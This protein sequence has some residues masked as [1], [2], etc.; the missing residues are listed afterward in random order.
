MESNEKLI[1]MHP[2][3]VSVSSEKVAQKLAKKNISPSLITGLNKCAASWLADTFVIRDLIEEEPDN[4]ARRGTLFHKVMED[5]FALPKEER[6]HETLKETYTAVLASDEFK[7]MAEMREAVVWLRR[8]INNYLNMGAQP[9]R[10]NVAT[11]TDAKGRVHPGLEVFVKGQI[12]NARRPTLGFIDRLVAV[13]PDSSTVLIEDWKTGGTAKRWNPATKSDDG[14][15]EARQQV[16]YSMLLEQEYGKKVAGARLIFPMALDP[17]WKASKEKDESKP[18]Y[19]PTLVEVD[20]KDEAFRARVVR[21]V[22]EADKKL[23]MMIE[24]NEFPYTPNFLCA[25]CPLARIC[26]A[27]SIKPYKKMQD[28]Y[29][30]QP[31]PELLLQTIEVR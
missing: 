22:E 28:A 19:K 30:Q 13:T 14:L 2:G 29:A 15:G 23:D 7:D 12:G 3:G 18:E 25:W 10:V 6:T 1:V 20:V 8:A 31:P 21:D 16:I 17:K 26:P 9:Q 4:A 27:A 5:F 11:V 24:A